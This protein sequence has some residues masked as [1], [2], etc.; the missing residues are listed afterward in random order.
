MRSMDGSIVLGWTKGDGFRHGGA[1]ELPVSALTRHVSI[2]GA[3]GSG[4]STT[5]IVMARELAK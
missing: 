2:L 3:T 4:K 1:V 5:A